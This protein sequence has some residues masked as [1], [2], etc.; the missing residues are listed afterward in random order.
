MNNLNINKAA[1]IATLALASHEEYR[2]R[3]PGSRVIGS[4]ELK[5]LVFEPDSQEEL[6]FKAA[7]NA[8]SD[9]ELRDL[10]AVMYVGRGD[11]V[12]DPE[13]PASI[14]KAFDGHVRSCSMDNREQLI[15]VLS[16]KGAVIHRYLAQGLER[17][18]LMLR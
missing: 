14:R 12:D 7:M 9:D 17:V 18:R 4:G 8:L 16:G 15:D 13:D 1:T 6:A 5:D 2:Q 10:V 11:H 3:H